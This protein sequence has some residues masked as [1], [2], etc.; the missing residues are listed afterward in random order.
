MDTDGANPPNE[1][2]PSE[3][4]LL[5]GQQF[6]MH[7]RDV[8]AENSTVRVAFVDDDVAQ[9]SEEVRPALV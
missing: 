7:Q 4:V 5:H 8:G 2:T 1:L 9:V 3:I 6:A